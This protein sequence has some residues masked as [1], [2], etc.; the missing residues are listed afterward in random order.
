[1]NISKRRIKLITII[2]LLFLSLI[3]NHV[4]AE[5]SVDLMT[6]I[7]E[8]NTNFAAAA[9]LGEQN[10]LEKS[11]INIINV[12]LTFIG[13]FFIIM[14]IISGFQWMTSGGNEETITKA[15]KRITSSIIGVAIVLGAWV[16]ANAAMLLIQNKP[17]NGGWITWY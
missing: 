7:E 15:K 9:G 8:Q 5:E 1:M 6:K 3:V 11:I 16:I 13:L 2:G 17:L 10:D 14:I 12:I 4:H